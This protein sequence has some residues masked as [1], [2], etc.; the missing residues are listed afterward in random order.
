M[1]NKLK[2]ITLLLLLAF[3]FSFSAVAQERREPARQQES[4][5]SRADKLKALR[6]LVQAQINRT[7]K[8]LG[9]LSSVLSRIELKL[10]SFKE[11]GVS[12]SALER[13]L[14]AAAVLKSET[15]RGLSA[16]KDKYSSID[17]NE[18]RRSVQ[19]FMKE[20]K[21]LKSK[22]IELQ[23]SLRSIISEMKRLEGSQP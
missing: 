8:A 14:A 21:A 17:P 9:R 16:V 19:A 15:E 2:I 1:R 4:E 6:N 10:E 3:T 7:E 20:M 22:L 18:P 13:K 12:V 11:T 5:T 23:K